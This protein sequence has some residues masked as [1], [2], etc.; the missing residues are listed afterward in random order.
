MRAS[1]AEG[2]KGQ[3]IKRSLFPPFLFGLFFLLQPK[4]SVPE[5]ASKS[6]KEKFAFLLLFA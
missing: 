5:F 2:N 4:G 3:P 1:F 6:G